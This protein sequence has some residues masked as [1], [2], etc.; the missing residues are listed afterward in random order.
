M[1]KIPMQSA[2]CFA[3]VSDSSIRVCNL[4]ESEGGKILQSPEIFPPVLW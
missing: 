3:D 1:D 2:Q 4:I